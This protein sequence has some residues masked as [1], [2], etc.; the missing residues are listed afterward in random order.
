M[1]HD[2]C[3]PA[4]E[5]IDGLYRT[6]SRRVFASLVR[7]LND[8][9]LADDAMHEAFAAAIEAWPREGAPAYPTAW[10]VSTGRFRAIDA[11]RRQGRLNELGPELV[12]RLDEVAEVN[13]SRA[14]VEIEDDR[15][16]LI[17][18]CCHPEIDPKLQVPLTLREVC[19]LTTEEI[20]RAFLTSKGTMAQRIV[21]GKA[22]IREQQI[23]FVVPSVRELPDRLDAVLSTIYLVFNEGYA[24]SEGASLTRVD[25]TGEAIRLGRLLLELL[26][27][28]EVKGLLALM[29]LHES[30]RASRVSEEGE[31]ILLEDQDRT[32]WNQSMILE[33][34]AL[35]E[36]ALRS[37]RFGAY[38]IQAAISA[39]H[40][41]AATLDETDWDQIIV[42]YSI[43]QRVDRSPVIELNR[44]VAIA[45]R[46]GPEA[47][48][49]LIDA[50]LNRG[51][52][53][54]YQFVHSARGEL[55]R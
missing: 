12:A 32:R 23:P 28:P 10:L 35:V 7:L 11:L 15:L 5:L 52:L 31:I 42:L 47:G 6:E 33:G 22:R 45:M 43:L 3:H 46:D 14:A 40:S 49:E 25:L 51:G 36:E 24:A 19:G 16:R 37:R 41:E 21:R 38:T 30:R 1:H 54:G 4:R 18:T 34:R 2:S 8:F 48:L 29:L 50:I 44:A 26:P 55:L 39:V 53:A 27:D 13:A 9:D 20:A 17:F